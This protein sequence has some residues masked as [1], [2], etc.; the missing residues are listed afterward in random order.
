M[1]KIYISAFFIVCG[2]QVNG[3]TCQVSGLAS[4]AYA[5]VAQNNIIVVDLSWSILPSA[6]KYQ[7]QIFSNGSISVSDSTTSHMINMEFLQPNATYIWRVRAKCNGAWEEWPSWQDNFNTPSGVLCEANGHNAVTSVDG[8]QSN[9]ISVMLSWSVNAIADEYQAQILYNGNLSVSTITTDTNVTMSNLFPNV[10]YLWRIRVKCN[11]EWN[12]WPDWQSSFNTPSGEVCEASDHASNVT[13]DVTTQSIDAELSWAANPIA[14]EY[15]VQIAN[16]DVTSTSNIT[17]STQITMAGLTENVNYLWRIRVKC[18]GTWSDWPSWQSSFDTPVIPNAWINELHYDNVGVDNGE[19]VEIVIENVGQYVPITDF[20]VTLYNGSDGA[21]YS[22]FDIDPEG[23][24]I[25]GDTVGDFS[26][27]AYTFPSN[28]IQNGGPDGIA[29]DYKGTTIQFISYEGTFTATDGAAQGIASEDILVS[30]SG[31]TVVG[32]SLQLCCDGFSYVDMEWQASAPET[33]GSSNQS[34][35][36]PVQ[37][38]YFKGKV[39]ESEVILNWLTYSELNND[40]FLIERSLDGSE[41]EALGKQKGSGTS[42]QPHT[43][44]M[45]DSLPGNANYYRLTQVDYDGTRTV[46]DIIQVVKELGT[47]ITIFPNP[48]SQYLTIQSLGFYANEP[49]IRML[50]LSGKEVVRKEIQFISGI[51]SLDI[52]HLDPGIY[53]IHLISEVE[54]TSFRVSVY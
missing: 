29:L 11:G 54:S 20:M 30:E 41:F 19:F 15:Q 31:T 16:N 36:L 35:I 21:A 43:Y 13:Y 53:T 50:D 28:G 17:T 33:K 8:M 4:N 9:V 32:T 48:A 42:D 26:F 49:S 5:D 2:L 22:N 1:V 52:A 6:E 24:S 44:M 18:N 51:Y 40:Y 37:L 39:R 14:E 23:P 10:T 38:G 25:T 7:A 47:N 12:A 3:Q 34:Q 46:Y 27:Y 45:T